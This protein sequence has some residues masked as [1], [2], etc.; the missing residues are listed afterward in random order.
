MENTSNQGGEESL[1]V[2]LLSEQVQVLMNSFFPF[3]EGLIPLLY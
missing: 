1:E 3:E 2:P